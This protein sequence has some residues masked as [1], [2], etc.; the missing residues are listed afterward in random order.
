MPPREC[1]IEAT[2]RV[3]AALARAGL[4]SALLP[5]V[6]Q[7]GLLAFN[8]AATSQA[9]AAAA[10]RDEAAADRSDATPRRSARI[11]RRRGDKEE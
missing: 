10:E 7:L 1:L 6:A 4:S 3:E 11:S 5:A 9:A 2:P 8:E